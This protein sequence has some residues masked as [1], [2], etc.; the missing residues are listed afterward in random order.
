MIYLQCGADSLIGDLIGRFR[1][2][3]EGHGFAIQKVLASGIPTILS[4]GGGYTIQNVA[5]CWAYETSLACGI[6]IPNK[7]PED[8]YFYNYYKD[9]PYLHIYDS[10]LHKKKEEGS[11]WIFNKEQTHSYAIYD[12]KLYQERV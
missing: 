7:L 3:S 4:G 10:V 2:S 11:Y 1:L 6:E 5:R 8:L 9:E 12:D